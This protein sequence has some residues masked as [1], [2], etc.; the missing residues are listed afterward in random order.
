MDT[1]SIRSFIGERIS[2]VKDI[3]LVD[4]NGNR[5][6]LRIPKQVGPEYSK[7]EID[8]IV[9]L[10]YNFILEYSGGKPPEI[11]L[12]N[13]A[14]LDG[15]NL[16]IAVNTFELGAKSNTEAIEDNDLIT[17]GQVNKILEN[18]TPDKL[19]DVTYTNKEPVPVGLGG[20][21]K[22]TTFDKTPIQDVIT[23]LL[24]P[25]Q[26]PAI[27]QFTSN[28]KQNFKLGESTGSNLILTWNTS[29]QDNI[30][31]NSITF[32]F[33]NKELPKEEFP[34]QGSKTFTVEPVALQTQGSKTIQMDMYDIKNKKISKTITL[35]W[36]N[37]IY[38]GN[39]TRETITAD[40]IPDL[41]VID[42]NSIGRDY[43][44]PGGGYKYLVFPASWSDPKSFVDPSTNFDVP[45]NKQ[46]NLSITN[47][48]GVTQ[49]YKVY[50]SV[51]VL[52]GD[53]TI[54]VKA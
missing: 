50:R 53:I 26:Q 14:K 36:L 15:E 16:Y 10:L 47:E 37:G 8:Y 17:L 33:N 46:N 12:S 41:T 27:T 35:T 38:Y 20:V 13:Y 2:N 1:N 52:N 43:K 24:Y 54:R 28:L 11:D 30:K 6:L 42:A 31:D 44:Y 23:M 49:D 21:A 5:K 45:M 32:Y 40:N 7:K 19:P 29:N 48:N 22:G 39:N 18:Y 9:N 51:N 25:Y 34:K 4:K 3:V